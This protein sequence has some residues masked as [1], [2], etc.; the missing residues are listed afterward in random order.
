MTQLNPTF[1]LAARRRLWLGAAAAG[2]LAMAL[3]ASAET[4]QGALAK[5]YENNPTLAAARAGQRAN[6]ENVPLQRGAGLP[7][8]NANVTYREDLVIPANSFT[9][10]ERLVNV[11]G[12]IS[13]PLYQ[14]GAVRAA[15]VAAQERGLAGQADLR[16]T[17]ASVFS[18]VVGAYMDVIRDRAIVGLNRSNVSVL[19]TNLRATRDRFEIG[20]LT[21]TDVAQSEARLALVTGQ[22]RG[23]EANLIASTEAYIR[24]VG[25][26]PDDLD[27]PPA[28]PGLPAM[29]DEAVAI[30]LANNPDL[31]AIGHQ[32]AAASKD[33]TAAR[34]T[35][36]PQV[37]ANVDSAY[38]S[39]LGT[40]GSAVPGLSPSQTARSVQA[41]VGVSIPIFQGGRPSARV[42]QAQARSSQTIEQGV[43]IE[44]AVIAQ[45]RSAWAAWQ[46]SEQVIR[47]NE[48][49][50]AANS[51]SLEGVRAENSV[52]TRSILDI[53]NAEQE[54]LNAQVQLVSA[55]RNAYVAAFTLLA[56]MGRAEAR[57]LGLD[58]GALYDPD[59]NRRRVAGQ[60]WDWADDPSPRQQST[61]TRD[62]AAPRM[63][64][65]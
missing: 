57:H 23:A 48:Q 46:A 26:A 19:E 30:A 63:G 10:P 41:T 61:S 29:V 44:R 58:G 12:R 2:A 14:G 65:N 9:A 51:L 5:A 43:A 20:D 17:E 42:R 15:T 18:Q 33:I 50:V 53:L 22:L 8:A 11:S 34:A 6:D 13:V 59:V 32:Q 7:S 3:P 56:A 21:R 52:G 40:L 45:T 31:E 60:V 38:T 27:A 39:F 28:L 35:R 1:K 47:A 49:A 54:L 25:E 64:P 16:A 36:L 62:I 55:Q 37:T 4:L 24:L